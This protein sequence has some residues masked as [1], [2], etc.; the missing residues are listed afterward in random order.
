[1]SEEKPID[2]ETAIAILRKTMVEAEAG[3][4]ASG[5]Q[6]DWRGNALELSIN[7]G[8]GDCRRIA[9]TCRMAILI[10]MADIDGT[11]LAEDETRVLLT[12]DGRSS[13]VA[14]FGEDS[15]PI[16]ISENWNDLVSRLPRTFPED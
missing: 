13:S 15:S 2:G 11:L 3:T 6:L 10:I 12:C 5:L 8:D 14:I 9:E 16:A 7:I 4:L 1:M